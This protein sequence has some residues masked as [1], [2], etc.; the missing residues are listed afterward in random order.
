MDILAEG[1]KP[2]TL[3]RQELGDAIFEKLK[4][5][6][7]AKEKLIGP[8]AMRYHERMIMLSVIDPQWKDHLRDMDHLKEGIGL[9]GYGQHDPLVEYKRESFDMFEA[10]MQRFQEDTVRYLY[11]MQILERPTQV[12]VAAA[13]VEGAPDSNQIGDG[14]GQRRLAI[15]TSVDDIE[16]ASQRKKAANWNR[17]GWPG[18]AKSAGPAGGS[19]TKRSDATIPAP[20][21]QAKNTRSAAGPG[22][23]KAD[24]LRLAKKSGTHAYC[25]GSAQMTSPQY[26]SAASHRDHRQQR[27]F[28][29]SNFLFRRF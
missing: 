11:L 8:D 18:A 15:S 4:E 13:E 20:A 6:Y 9:R 19:R 5:R 7:D 29:G 12:P 27:I 16:E 17:R 1:I 23:S 10:M 21:A 3:N 25:F 2:E 14:D 26:Y 22:L 24:S 28:S